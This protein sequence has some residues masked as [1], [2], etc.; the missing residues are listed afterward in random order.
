MFSRLSLFRRAALAPAPMRMSFRTIYQKTEDELPRRIVPK[1][2]T[3][4]SANPNHEDRINR[5]ERLLRK[6]IKLPSQNNNEAQQTKAPWISFDEYALIGGGTRLK[7]TQYTQLLYMLNKLHNIDPQLT[8]DE[9]TSE[10]SQYYKKSSMLSNNIKIKTL[11]EFG[12]S[13]AVGKRK[14]STAKVFVVRGTGEILVNGRQLND[15]FLKMKDRESIMYPLQV[16][17]SVGK[18]NIFATTSGG[19]PTGQAESIMHAI[20][21]ALVVFNPL[22]KSRLHIAGVL[23]RDYRH[24]ERKKPGKKKA[25]KMPT[26]VKR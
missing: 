15:Y 1:L 13:I 4:Y 14:S 26:W 22:L 16:I 11:D 18:Y 5:L 19:G 12:R 9:I 6:Y 21:K 20:A 3:F 25:R 7:P 17:E 24:V 8:N 23:T 2:A 10:L